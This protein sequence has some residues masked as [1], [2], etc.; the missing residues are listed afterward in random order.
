MSQATSS[1]KP[2][3][4]SGRADAIGRRSVRTSVSLT[5]FTAS[6]SV[7]LAIVVAA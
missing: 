4:N 6:L 3:S 7:S 5:V 1:A 2:A